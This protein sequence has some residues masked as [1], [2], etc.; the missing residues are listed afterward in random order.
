MAIIS[1]A[2]LLLKALRRRG[3]EAPISVEKE[4][5]DFDSLAKDLA[6]GL[7]RREALRRLGVG[8]TGAFLASLSLRPAWSQAAACDSIVLAKCNAHSQFLCQKK[9]DRCFRHARVSDPQVCE[10]VYRD[11]LAQKA[12]DCNSKYGCANGQAC[13]SNTC[14]NTGTDSSHCG[15]CGVV[16]TG[17]KSCVGGQCQCPVDRA[18]CGSCVDTGTDPSNCG[19]CGI[20]CPEGRPCVSGRC[21]TCGAAVCDGVSTDTCT[22]PDHCGTCANPCLLGQE[23]VNGQCQ[24]AEVCRPPEICVNGQ[25]LCDGIA[26]TQEGYVCCG[27]GSGGSCPSDTKCCGFDDPLVLPACCR[28]DQLCCQKHTDCPSLFCQSGCCT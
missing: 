17:G 12:G 4:R 14:V 16:C 5:F 25:C 6:G 10:Q 19:G 13:C 1:R 8:L 7:S 15:A 3:P 9:R 21:N 22:D 23:C 20:V 11:C 28:L 26:V 2:D 27:T 18:D 24:C